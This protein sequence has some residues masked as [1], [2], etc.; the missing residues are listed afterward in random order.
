M[1]QGGTMDQGGA[2]AV[3]NEAMTVGC[4]QQAG[5]NGCGAGEDG[6]GDNL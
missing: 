4:C 3:T 1:D 2:I 5:W 6:G